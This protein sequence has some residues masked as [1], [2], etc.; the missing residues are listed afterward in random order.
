[1]SYVLINR[2]V[3]SLKAYHGQLTKQQLKTLRGQALCGDI[4]DAQKG[5]EKLLKRTVYDGYSKNISR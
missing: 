1:M 4:G 5:L 3:K 2:F